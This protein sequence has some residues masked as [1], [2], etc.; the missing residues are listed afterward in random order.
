MG[1]GVHVCTHHV[2]RNASSATLSIF[3]HTWEHS[4][5]FNRSVPIFN[6][7]EQTTLK[8]IAFFQRS[9][10]KSDTRPPQ[11]SKDDGEKQV[12]FSGSFPLHLS[13]E[14]SIA[15]PWLDFRG[16]LLILY[17]HLKELYLIYRAH[18]SLHSLNNLKVF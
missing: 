16:N 1:E 8:R 2:K 17:N 12:L 5:I 11:H 18:D 15:A 7:S 14:F 9:I 3:S 10:K 13:P 6:F 4:S